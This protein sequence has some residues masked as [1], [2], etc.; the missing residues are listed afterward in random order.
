MLFRA[1]RFAVDGVDY[2]GIVTSGGGPGRADFEAICR[3]AERIRKNVGIKLCASLGMLD[4]SQAVALRR[5]GFVSCHHNLETARS[6]YPSVCDSHEYEARV[7]TVRNAKAAGLRVCSGGLF[8]IGETWAQRL[9]LSAELA[10]LEVDSI[11]VNFL[12]PIPGT[13]LANAAPP[14]ATTA[15]AVIALLRLMHPRRDLVICGGREKSLGRFGAL[16]FAAGANGI[17]VGNYLTAK[18]VDSAED[19]LLLQTLG[20]RH[21]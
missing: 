19:R 12:I 5:A 7:R 21:G 15:L 20:L 11:P 6:H 16:V 2:M 1:E 10:A 13:P 18:G 8:G 14:T 3:M 9:E 4:A 17:M